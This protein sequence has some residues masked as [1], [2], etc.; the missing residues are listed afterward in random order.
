[1]TSRSVAPRG[2][3]L[4]L[5]PREIALQLVQDLLIKK[6]YHSKPEKNADAS[7][8]SRLPA[9]LQHFDWDRSLSISLDEFAVGMHK[10]GHEGDPDELFRCIDTDGS[11]EI[12]LEEIHP[13]GAAVWRSFQAWCAQT[14]KDEEDAIKQLSQGNGEGS[15]VSNESFAENCRRL[16]WRGRQEKQLFNS[17]NGGHAVSVKHLVWLGIAKRVHTK[18]H[19]ATKLGTKT[20]ATKLRDRRQSALQALHFKSFLKKRF[21][22]GI[23]VWLHA[24]DF[25][26]AMKIRKNEFLK[27][28]RHVGFRGDLQLVWKGLDRNCR[29]ILSIEEFDLKAAQLLARFKSWSSET[30]G[31]IAQA[32]EAFDLAKVGRINESNFLKAC[33]RHG[34]Q[35]SKELFM[36]LDWKDSGYLIQ[37]DMTFVDSWNAPSYLTAES[38]P[39]AASEFKKCLQRAGGT[40]LRA[41]R[42]HFD[43]RGRNRIS[44]DDFKIGANRVRFKGD[45]AGAWN[46]L[47][48]GGAFL[49]LDH[50]DWESTTFVQ[51]FKKWTD[52]EFGGV[53]AAFH[54]FDADYNGGLTFGEFRQ[55][56]MHHGY[57][58][59][60]MKTLFDALD[61]QGDGVISWREIAFMEDWETDVDR[62]IEANPMVPLPAELQ[63]LA[64]PEKESKSVELECPPRINELAQPKAHSLLSPRLSSEGAETL[65][66]LRL[67]ELKD[68]ILLRPAPDEEELDELSEAREGGPLDFEMLKKKT[69]AL[70]QR[71]ISLLEKDKGVKL[72]QT[73][74]ALPGVNLQGTRHNPVWLTNLGNRPKRSPYDKLF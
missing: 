71:T 14:F 27:A 30:F 70:Q 67:R 54:F 69:A 22:T 60:K 4:A 28:T 5:D 40:Y 45:L 50:I 49:T 57:D 47:A 62:A 21:S 31:S 56:L 8:L 39:T 59:P 35:A 37:Q 36:N 44:W 15:P 46:A 34:Y 23:R 58:G 51:Q 6:V 16:G 12:E 48:D 19:N 10:L 66:S 2:A 42:L 61:L 64:E 55:A 26:G 52:K 3:V 13:E 53:Q 33:S 32:L 29:D 20:Y 38:N 17:L 25:K 11:G 24:I 7:D 18:H 72:K 65:R 74:S 68:E 41:W 1:M 63:L 73:T 43:F 9:W